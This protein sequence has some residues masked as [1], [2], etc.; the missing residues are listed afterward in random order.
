MLVFEIFTI[1]FFVVLAGIAIWYMIFF[2][3]D[4]GP[5]FWKVTSGF[6][7][8]YYIWLPALLIPPILWILFPPEVYRSL[9]SVVFSDLVVQ[10]FALILKTSPFWLPPVLVFAALF[11]W[12][13]LKRAEFLH[14]QKYV[15]LEFKLPPEQAKSPMAMELALSAFF[16]TGRETTFIDRVFF[17]RVR[18]YFSLEIASMEGQVH[19]YIWTDVLFRQRIEAAMYS[20]YPGVEITEVPDYTAVVPEYNP[21]TH[22]GRIFELQ[23]KAPDPLPIRTYID[24]KLDSDPEEESKID[25]LLP[26]LEFIGSVGKGEYFWI[27]YIFRAH[28]KKPKPGTIFGEW[29][30]TDESHKEIEKIL[31]NLKVKDDEEGQENSRGITRFE[32]ELLMAIDRNNSKLQFDAGLR[33]IYL[34]EKDKFR[35]GF[36]SQQHRLFHQF[37]DLGR[38]KL[39]VFRQGGF[40]YPWQDYKN[41]RTNARRRQM[42]RAFR[43]RGWFFGPYE[44]PIFVL[45]AE[46]LATL[47]HLPGKV[48]TTPTLGR[49]VSRK[50]DA[51]SNLPR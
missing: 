44:R 37:T 47:W 10:A 38:N 4:A 29:S 31:K 28:S 35:G 43:T 51:P 6:L 26:I 27:Q 39:G 9:F 20:Q 8:L 23:L 5:M 45:S 7:R 50:E 11:N 16:Q 48:A 41:I 24:F 40:D 34:A 18:G 49:V 15:V 30:V 32:Q 13:K 22:D 14:S 21:E 1:T 12:R 2:E 3:D 36:G 25:P 42:Y 33:V 17:G 19:F 46:E